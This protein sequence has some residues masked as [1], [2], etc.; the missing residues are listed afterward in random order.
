MS[1]AAKYMSA[2]MVL[3]SKDRKTTDMLQYVRKVRIPIIYAYIL[4]DV[5]S[6]RTSDTCKSKTVG[7][8]TQR[9]TDEGTDQGTLV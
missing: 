1:N 9:M 4:W 2:L 8:S 5:S 6:D 7:T 3:P